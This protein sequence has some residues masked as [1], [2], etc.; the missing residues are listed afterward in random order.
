MAKYILSLFF[1]LITLVEAKEYT[2]N[3]KGEEQKENFSI[4]I[5][6]ETDEE[7]KPKPLQK[8]DIRNLNDFKSLKV[9][10]ASGL[11]GTLVDEREIIV[12]Y[13]TYLN[14]HGLKIRN[15]YKTAL[16]RVYSD[17]NNITLTFDKDYYQNIT[18]YLSYHNI[19]SETLKDL[20]NMYGTWKE[21]E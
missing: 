7:G 9:I 8:I 11:K 15:L 16:T 3:L 2:L 10:T 21:I 19:N 12:Y 5:D 4:K 20:D 6:L 1:V 17:E 13:K 14:T 18:S